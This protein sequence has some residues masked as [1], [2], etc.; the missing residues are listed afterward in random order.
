MKY[1]KRIIQSESKNIDHFIV[2]Q[3]SEDYL[4]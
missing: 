4:I 2:T 3:I 1:V